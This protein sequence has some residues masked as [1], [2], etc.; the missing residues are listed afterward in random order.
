MLRTELTQWIDDLLQVSQFKD[1][2]PNGLQVEG[3]LNVQ[4]ILCAVTASRAVIEKAIE[5]QADTLLVHHGMFWKSEPSTIIGWKKQRIFKLLQNNINLLAYH[6]PLD[7]HPE[8]GNNAQLAQKLGYTV[9]QQVEEQGLLSLCISQEKQTL[10][11]LSQKITHT[12]KRQP[13]VIGDGN[14]TIHRIGIC[15]GGGQSFFQAATLYG[16]DAFITGEA[17]EAQYHLANET[18]TAFIAAG[19]HATER[20]GIQALSQKIQ[21]QWGV[22]CVFFDE[23]NPI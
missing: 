20:Y 9:C 2:A 16:I 13:L 11:Q 18:N 19:H 6:L 3:C 21:Q 15:T 12:L 8:I 5:I 23:E 22:E 17:S 7:A 14:Q 4:K 1:Y 10:N